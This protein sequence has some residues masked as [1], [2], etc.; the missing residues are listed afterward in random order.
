MF[1]KLSLVYHQKYAY[2][3]VV[4]WFA[5][6]VEDSRYPFTHVRQSCFLDN[7]QNDTSGPFY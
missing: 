3:S 1:L 7:G 6:L 5:K 4:T 2:G